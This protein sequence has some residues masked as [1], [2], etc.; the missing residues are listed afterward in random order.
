MSEVSVH[1]L[2][3][4]Y[5][6]SS[7]PVLHDINLEIESGS[8]TAFVGQVGAGKS[9]LFRT[10]NGL[11]PTIVPG[12]VEGEIVVAGH[13]VQ[14]QDP[15][16][17]AQFINLVF[18][19]PVLQIVNLTAEEDVAFGPANLNLPREEVWERTYAAMERVGLVGFEKRDPR[20]MSGG[21]QQLLALAGILA[22][23]PRII[24]MDEPVAM[25]DPIGK[26][27]VLD[28]IR[29]LK[30][31]FGATILIAESGVDIEPVCEFAD[32][33]VLMHK[34][35]ILASGC[36]GEVFAR[37]DL[38]AQSGL[39]IPQVTR[40]FY[41]L[42]STMMKKVPVTLE[43]SRQLVSQRLDENGSRLSAEQFADSAYALAETAAGDTAEQAIQ[44]KNL[45]HVFPTDPP[46][47]ALKGI[48]L[49]I[50]KGDFVA[51]LGQNGSG[52][53]T[54]SFHLVGVEEPTNPDA[55]ITVDGLDVLQS[56]LSQVVRR[57]NYLFQNPANQLFC[58]T[59]GEEV[60]FGPQALGFSP[61]ESEERGRAALRQVGLEQ[62]WEYFTLSVDKSIETLLSLATVLAMDPHILIADE[63][64][65][66]LDYA[67]GNKLMEILQE[68]NR[69]G[70]TIVVITH[71]MELAVRYARRIV[72]LRHGEVW[73]DGT[74]QE[75][76]GQ[77]ARLAET[78]LVPPQVT[79]L[80]QSLADYGFPNNVLS[81]EEFVALTRAA[82]ANGK[83]V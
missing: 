61:E 48:N 79:R 33:M 65:G 36:P 54:L 47:H 11:I 53:S 32:Q 43:E 22:M 1:N 78:R 27:Q 62:Y 19:D 51:L 8:V 28:A 44:V 42:D 31:T 25:L 45:H 55:A 2:T 82:L 15:A 12:K 38:V 52:K 34:G 40:V 73:M 77:P 67:T 46:V 83:E 59:F 9:T 69:Q 63:P 20:S 49:D 13:N 26:T 75:V 16:F 18:D 24:A 68:L 81:V 71:D 70:R 6:R 64:T 14:D 58:Q 3:V 35:R 60:A 23:R 17:M 37:H 5:L 57:I 7:Q 21:E 80:A 66:G 39:K 41:Q 74:P 10:F 50:Q 29:E 30:D 4:T 72:I 56:P 76:F